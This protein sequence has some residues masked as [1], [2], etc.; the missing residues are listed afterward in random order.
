MPWFLRM[1]KPTPEEVKEARTRAG[2]KQREAA[3]L[4]HVALRAWQSWED[5]SRQM[6]LTAWELFN[7]KTGDKK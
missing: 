2:L 5:G 1:E 6:S 4:V 3:E 7:I